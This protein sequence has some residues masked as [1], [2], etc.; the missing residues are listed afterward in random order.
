MS[1]D[2]AAR[3]SWLL[4]TKNLTASQLANLIQIQKSSISHIMSGRNK[5]SF[6][7]LLKLKNAFP[8]LNLDWFVTGEGNPF[9]NTDQIETMEPVPNKMNKATTQNNTYSSENETSTPNRINHPVY[10]SKQDDLN[11]I[12][13]VYDDDTYKILKPRTK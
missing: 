7:F 2:I 12:V 13:F 6:D 4:E 9:E 8:E 5:P 11:S 3:L 1:K 10:K